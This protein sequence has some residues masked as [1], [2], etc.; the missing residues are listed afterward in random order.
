MC[1]VWD[2]LQNT[3][4]CCLL[5]AKIWC[6]IP[7]LGSYCTVFVHFE[8][9]KIKVMLMTTWKKKRRN[10]WHIYRNKIK[11]L[12]KYNT[13]GTTIKFVERGKPDTTNTRIHERAH[14]S[15]GTGTSIYSGGLN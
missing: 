9:I 10:S 5:S 2:E 13:V 4:Y 1:S 8:Y 12:K 11:Y 14:S 6:D 7:A 3:N 15:L